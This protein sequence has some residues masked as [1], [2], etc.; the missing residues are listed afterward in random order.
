[1]SEYKI[2][3]DS[4]ASIIGVCVLYAISL[5]LFWNSTVS[6]MSLKIDPANSMFADFVKGIVGNKVGRQVGLVGAFVS[7]HL[8]WRYRTIVGRWLMLRFGQ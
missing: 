7:V 8:A 1:M 5:Y 4:V 2:S 3:H 6:F